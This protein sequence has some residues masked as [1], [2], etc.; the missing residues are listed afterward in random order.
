M[1]LPLRFN[2]PIYRIGTRGR[3]WPK[4]EKGQFISGNLDTPRRVAGRFTYHV[5]A[6]C[7]RSIEQFQGFLC[8]FAIEQTGNCRHN[9]LKENQKVA[10]TTGTLF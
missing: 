6:L 8:N 5:I 7:F 2:R 9:G 4:I 3:F 1:E 10:I